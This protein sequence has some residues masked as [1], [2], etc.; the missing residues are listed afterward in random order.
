MEQVS[1]SVGTA[2]RRAAD[3]DMAANPR[4]LPEMTCSFV[5]HEG[6]SLI[7]KSIEQLQRENAGINIKIVRGSAMKLDP[8][9]EFKVEGSVDE[10]QAFL[11][12]LYPS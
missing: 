2:T 10:V 1:G 3:K 7:G 11:R 6:L 5:V 8:G 4:T 9:A 12:K